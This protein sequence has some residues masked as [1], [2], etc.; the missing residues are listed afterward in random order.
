MKM[1]VIAFSVLATLI[2][3][4]AGA[5]LGLNGFAQPVSTTALNQAPRIKNLGWLLSGFF[6]MYLADPKRIGLPDDF[7]LLWPFV[8][9]GVG[10][11]AG[12]LASIGWMAHSITLSVQAFNTRLPSD[13]QLD[14][15]LFRREYL[16]YGKA[17]FDER[18]DKARAEAAEAANV[19]VAR[20]RELEQ[21][22]GERRRELILNAN[23]AAAECVYNTLQQCGSQRKI[24][25]GELMDSVLK[26]ICAMAAAATNR[27]ANLRSSYMAFIPSGEADDALIQKALF[28]SGM[29]GRYSGYLELKRGS[30]R[31]NREVVL[32]IAVVPEFVLPGPP[33]AVLNQDFSMMNLQ[34]IKF[35]D[36]V[37]KLVGN[38]IR[39][40]YKHPHF[41]QIASIASILVCDMRRLHGVVNIESSE[42]D[43]FSKDV[44]ASLKPLVALL[45]VF[46]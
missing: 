2:G 20:D 14:P 4:V 45:S 31:L 38:E 22:K 13:Q 25:E 21:A 30:V 36:E 41:H 17:R 15:G 1:S 35:K 44:V 10:A 19:R 40:F 8:G 29:P 34:N 12:V 26:A 18:W 24:P 42:Q 3:A 23:L 16:T 43:L 28:T 6:V 9:Y 11:L 27:A 7:P 39:E 37:S 32:P 46:R 33:E 5:V